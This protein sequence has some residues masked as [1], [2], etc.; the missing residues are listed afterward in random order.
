MDLSQVEN[1]LDRKSD[2]GLEQKGNEAQTSGRCRKHPVT[3]K[4][5]FYGQ[6]VYQRDLVIN[7]RK[8]LYPQQTSYN[9]DLKVCDDGTLV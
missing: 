6:Q 4:D 3:R 1:A 5:D 8:A 9:N 2:D 7:D